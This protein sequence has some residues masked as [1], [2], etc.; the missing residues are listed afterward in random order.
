MTNLE[1]DG[2]S[3]AGAKYLIIFTKRAA[4]IISQNSSIFKR[5][6]PGG[7]EV[8][9]ITGDEREN[10][11][12]SCNGVSHPLLPQKKVEENATFHEPTFTLPFS[13]SDLNAVPEGIVHVLCVG[14]FGGRASKQARASLALGMQFSRF[15]SPRK[16][17]RRMP[18]H[19]YFTNIS[20]EGYLQ[21][22]KYRRKAL[23][24]D[25]D[26]KISLPGGR[27]GKLGQ[28]YYCPATCLLRLALWQF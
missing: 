12:G 16:G 19:F 23:N 10:D 20:P 11:V 17:E 22:H 18:S 25:N 13:P 28:I 14:S 3:S 15:F 1:K 9:E 5:G 2:F 27:M 21:R 6:A 7:V 8:K 24:L 26:K 4:R